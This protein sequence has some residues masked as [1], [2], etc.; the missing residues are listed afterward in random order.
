[1]LRPNRFVVALMIATIQLGAICSYAD[2]ALKRTF[3]NSLNGFRISLPSD[4]D[5]VPPGNLK[6]F[7]QSAR[8]QH[9]DWKPP[10]L[11]DAFLMTNAAG[12]AFPAYMAIRVSAKPS[13]REAILADLKAGIPPQGVQRGEPAFVDELNAYVIDY[14][15]NLGVRAIDATI[16]YFPTEK[17]VIQ[18]FFLFPSNQPGLAALVKDIIK[19]VRISD[20]IKA[21]AERPMRGGLIISLVAVAAI[22]IVLSRAKS[23]KAPGCPSAGCG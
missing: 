7:D 21:P 10:I 12:L 11:Q 1:M 3:T 8:D 6:A 19:H 5:R 18:M 17:S 9:P 4:W 23:A 20:E 22:I 2:Q 16:A 13:N 15:L 14:Q